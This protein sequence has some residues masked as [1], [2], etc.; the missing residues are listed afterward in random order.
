VNDQAGVYGSSPVV[1]VDVNV[2]DGSKYTVIAS[3]DI[4]RSE[5]DSFG[6]AI[7]L[8]FDAGLGLSQ[9]QFRVR[10]WGRGEVVQLRTK[11]YDPRNDACM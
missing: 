3:R 10:Y 5:L 1:T 7:P 2:W 8:K 4:F 6:K 11:I 9:Y